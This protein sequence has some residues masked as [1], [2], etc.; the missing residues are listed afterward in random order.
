MIWQRTLATL[1]VAAVGIAVAPG[2]SFAPGADEVIQPAAALPPPPE[3]VPVLTAEPVAPEDGFVHLIVSPAATSE[4]SSTAPSEAGEPTDSIEAT[5]GQS[6]WT[7]SPEAMAALPADSKLVFVNGQLAAQLPSGE[8]V[9]LQSTP[10]TDAD[11]A[12]GTK[13]GGDEM[14]LVSLGHPVIDEL[15]A[16]PGVFD[17]RP[18]GDGSF[19]VAVESVDV[20]DGHALEI[21][22]DTLLALT[23]DPYQGYQWALENNGSNL[24]G[25]SGAPAQT[26]DADID[27]ADAWPHATGSGVVVAVIDSGVDFSHPD[28]TNSQWT[29]PGEL[30]GNGV[31]DDANGYVDDCHGWDFGYEDSTPFNPGANAHGTHVA[32]IIAAESGNGVGVSGVAPDATIMDLNV[33][34]LTANGQP[35][36]TSSALARAIRY[37]ADNGADIINLS[38]GTPPGTPRSA[39]SIVESAIVHAGSQGV[40]VAV[41]AGND[42]VSL[43][44]TKVWPASYD[45]PHVLTVAATAPDETLASFSNYGSVV[46]IAAPGHVILSTAPAANGSYVFM[47]GTSQA[48]PV[49]AGV[50]ALRLQSDPSITPT[51]LI[52]ALRDTSDRHQ[53]YTAYVPTGARVNAANVVGVGEPVH[54]FDEIAVS[55]SGLA[56]ASAD[57][58]LTASF[59]VVVPT[60][61]YPEP[62]RWE[63]GLYAITGDGTYALAGLDVAVDGDPMLTDGRGTVSTGSTGSTRFALSTTLPAGDYALVLEAVPIDD[64]DRRLGDPMVMSFSVASPQDPIGPSEP[65]PTEPGPAPAPSPPSPTPSEP[66][67]PDPTPTDP[68]PAPAPSPTPD[69]PTPTDPTPTNP[70]PSNPTPTNPTPSNPTPTDPTP[71]NPTPTDPPPS[72]PGPTPTE[73]SPGEPSPSEPDP[74]APAPPTT[75]DPFTPPPTTAPPTTTTPPP[76]T[77][78]PGATPPEPSEPGPAP[79]PVVNG[80]WRITGISPGTGPVATRTMV[81]LTG[82]F[83]EAAYVWFGEQP[84]VVVHQTDTTIDVITPLRADAGSVELTLRRTGIGT[85]LTV[86]GGFTFE[87][88]W[89]SEPA[90]GEPAPTDPYP[91]EPIPS[92]PGEP[93]SPSPTPPGT[94]PLEPAPTEPAP[95]T[96]PPTAPTP[97]PSPGDPSPPATDPP[98]TQPPTTTVPNARQD[99]S[100]VASELVDLGGGLLGARVLGSDPTSAATSCHTDPCRWG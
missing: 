92:E 8:I 49:V 62:Y 58:P 87:T 5:D 26:P 22:D 65:D 30:C 56:T 67:D 14:P 19:A 16:T 1:A 24:N 52:A 46:D 98:V 47:S 68:G 78:S 28:L 79:D 45:Y 13:P 43:D 25:V 33:G 61:E 6:G 37:A 99:R 54:G 86:P 41:A 64:P 85:I 59:D 11:S 32:G 72:D 69:G 81:R 94:E 90:P 82:S 60:D 48:T 74:A 89:P 15:A 97:E 12:I 93:S 71:S 21:T 35:S 44:A 2:L 70:T 27:A 84:G 80:D 31:D 77:D 83:P 75:T 76:T 18:I 55:V 39:L 88:D 3:V 40:L 51:E 63:T 42:S 66:T 20:L 96:P 17:I 7:V 36:I 38:L 57:Q 10:E 4:P 53:S 34:T 73:P 29:N 95:T 100:D 50:A 91:S 9:E 23:E